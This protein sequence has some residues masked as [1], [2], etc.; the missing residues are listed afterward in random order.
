[1]YSSSL[2][3]ESVRSESSAGAGPASSPSEVSVEAGGSVVVTTEGGARLTLGF[4]A[5]FPSSEATAVGFLG[6][7]RF[8]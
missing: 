8:F 1:M 7:G 3:G 6:G 4:F 5:S 2:V